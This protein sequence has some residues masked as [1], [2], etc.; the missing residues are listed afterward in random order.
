MDAGHVL[1]GYGEQAERIGV[2]HVLLDDEREGSQI[3]QRF[4]VARFD[5]RLFKRRAI[6]LDVVV[7]VLNRPL[8]PLELEL[9][10]LFCRHGFDIWLEI[11]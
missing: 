11:H 3:V 2:A 4:E 6:E 9:P 7:G 8:H 10:E 1:L 5:A